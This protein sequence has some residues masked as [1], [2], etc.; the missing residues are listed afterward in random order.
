ML[1]VLFMVFTLSLLGTLHLW[2]ATGQTAV[3][4]I[5]QEISNLERGVK[6]EEQKNPHGYRAPSR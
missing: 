4:R 5:W 3:G 2:H 6:T 1:S